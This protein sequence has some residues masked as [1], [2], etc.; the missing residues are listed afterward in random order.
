MAHAFL[1]VCAKAQTSVACMATTMLAAALLLFMAPASAQNLARGKPATQSSTYP[2]APASKAVDGNTNGNW[3][4]GSV[5]ITGS[6]LNAWW[7]VD[8]EAVVSIGR[9]TIYNRTDC[10]GNR[11]SNADIL[12]S[13]SPFPNRALNSTEVA[14]AKVATIG[15]ALAL[16]TFDL[17]AVAGRY[18]RVQLQGTAYLQLAEVEVFG[19]VVEYLVVGGGGGGGGGAGAQASNNGGGGG[20]GGCR[21]GFLA[22]APSTYSVVVGAGGAG[23]TTTARGSNGADSQFSSIT[24]AGGGAGGGGQSGSSYSALAG[25]NGG[26]GDFS[27][28]LN[29]A[30]GNTP[31][32]SPAQGFA[33]GNRR[34]GSPFFAGGGGGCGQAGSSTAGTGGNGMSSAISGTA[35]TYGGGG[36]GA[37]DNGP[38]LGGAGGGGNGGKGAAPVVNPTA[39][40]DNRGGGGGGSSQGGAAGISGARGGSGVV[41]IRYKTDGSDGI[42]APT[43]TGGTKTTSG[44]YT[45]HTFTTSGTFTVSSSPPATLIARY[46]FNESSYAGTAGELKDTAGFTG[47]PFNGRAQSSPLPSVAS[48][49]PARS[50]S[51]GTCGY[52]NLPGP[53]NNGG[54]FIINGLPVSTTAGAKTSVTFWMYWNGTDV[55][56]PLGWQAHDLFLSGGGFGFSTDSADVFGIANTGLSNVWRHVVAVFTN[57]SVTSNKIYIDGVLQTL[58]QRLAPATNA[59]AVV[60]STLR[61]GGFGATNGYRMGGRIDQLRVYNGELTSVQ[62]TAAFSE[63]AT[64]S[65]VAPHKLEIQHA[66]GTGLTCTP[67]TVTVRACA[68][69][70]CSTPYTGGVSGTLG[71]TGGSV[72]WPDTTAFSIPAG[73][74]T[75]TVRL[76]AATTTPTVL[77]VASSTPAASN[78]AT[79]NFGSPACT[80]TAADAGLL[81]D[82]PNLRAS[83]SASFSVQAVRKSDNSLACTPAFASVSRNITF[84]CSYTN[85]T[86]GTLPVLVAGEALNASNSAAAA[87]DAGGRAVSLAFNSSGVASASF[88]YDDAGQLTLTAAYTGSAATSDTGLAMSGSDS[89][90]SAPNRFTLAGITTGPI[91]AGSSFGATVTARN[92]GGGATPNFG[93]ETVAETLTTGWVRIQ[94]TGTGAADGSFSGGFGSFASGVAT[95]SNLAW[96][97]VGR[98]DLVVRSTNA[99]GYLG[100]GLSVY[101]SS[102]GTT[103]ICGD[104]GGSCVLPGG[105]TATVYYGENSSWVAKVGQ[106][107]T[108]ACN[109]TNF[110][111]PLPGVPKKCL[112]VDTSATNGSVGDFIPHRFTVAASNACGSFSYA[113]Q[114]VPATVTAQNAAGATTRNFNGTATTTPGFAQAVTLADANGLGVGSLS[115]HT[116]AANAFSAGVATASPSYSF[117]TKATAPQNLVLRATNGAS[118][119]SLISSQ[120]YAEPTLPLRSGRLHLSNTFGKAS[121]ALQVPVVAEYWGDSD[122]LLNSADSCTTLAGAS[123]ALSNPRG[124]TGAASTATSSAGALA[125]SAGSGSITLAAPS[126]AG[127]TLSLDIALNLGSTGTDQSC[128]SARPATTGA[129]RPWLRAQNGSCAATADRDPAARASFGIFAP[130]TRRTVHVR[131]VY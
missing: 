33:G 6:E 107:G 59:R 17:T 63:T 73:S 34:P 118:G 61:I 104:E 46:D 82:V 110:G 76:Q 7:Q 92:S 85:P 41:I 1:R 84:R 43:T 15:T 96:T 57:G 37:Q 9:I 95:A 122:W 123:V 54:G 77:G 67:S 25:G 106:T 32:T 28:T 127:S 56:M 3:S 22:V 105:T 51:P 52:A 40:T 11:L 103:V 21:T 47:G 50:G 12:V 80:F 49:S 111:D 109:S 128:N 112:Y 81:F 91:R 87:C 69:A 97:E 38:S 66:S 20:G 18:L 29:G 60:D 64:C 62:V 35:T 13:S 108:V 129:G 4:L 2:A 36:A 98:G 83:A 88:R 75:T 71:A 10:C 24:A 101:G 114:P 45:V 130:E 116:I 42:Y 115:G 93:R 72:V 39:G 74:S 48:A 68:D 8:L 90:I 120:G 5:A 65:V 55:V 117:T 14:A 86:T 124:A 94:P 26:G 119:G 30:A 79:C 102:R 31:A 131:D 19:S 44:I 113:G 121:A 126:P 16:H 99:S 125:I 23:G 27:F 89:V 53:S 58:T 70:A 100:S 78:A